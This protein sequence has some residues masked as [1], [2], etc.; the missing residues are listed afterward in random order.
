MPVPRWI[1]NT[2]LVFTVCGIWHGANWTFLVWGA[3]HGLLLVLERPLRQWQKNHP[4][5]SRPRKTARTVIGVTVTFM[6]VTLL[7]SVFRAPSFHALYDV[8]HALIHN[9]HLPST[10]TV[11]ANTWGA[12]AAFILLDI[13]LYNTRFDHWCAKFPGWFRWTIYAATIF[14]IVVCS[15][16]EK[17]PFIYFQF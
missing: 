5:I 16:V 4:D 10:L 12:L 11:D 1:F 3:G 7:W 13:L 8:H 17:Y 2:I 9:A 14:A 6:L 15:S